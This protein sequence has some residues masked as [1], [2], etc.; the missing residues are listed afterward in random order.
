MLIYASGTVAAIGIYNRSTIDRPRDFIMS[1]EVTTAKR[2]T[3]IQRRRPNEMR[4][5]II[6]IMCRPLAAR[7]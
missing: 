7:D 6:F 1:A 2:P 5:I 4:I 3:K